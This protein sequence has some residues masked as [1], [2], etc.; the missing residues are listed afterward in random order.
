MTGFASEEFQT[1]LRRNG[2]RHARVAPY[3]PAGNGQAERMVP[4]T[5]E[6]LKKM[7]GD[8]YTKIYRFLL[9]QHITP[10]VT[11]GRSPAELLMNRRINTVFD[12]LH[13]N[14]I[15]DMKNKQES[16]DVTGDLRTFGS[17]DQVFA[18]NFTQGPKWTPATVQSPL[19]PVSYRL[20]TR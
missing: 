11:T 17:R 3:H 18:R 5:K 16:M 1:F 2:V 13:P 8:I 14:F 15:M 9:H 6:V 19:G 20:I 7:S 12:K 4:T 10:H